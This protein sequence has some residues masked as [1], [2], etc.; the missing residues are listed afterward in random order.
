VQFTPRLRVASM[1]SSKA[2][3]VIGL[4]QWASNPAAAAASTSVAWPKPVNAISRIHA[5]FVFNRR[6]S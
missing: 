1:V 6:A 3:V 4:A 5:S 2:S